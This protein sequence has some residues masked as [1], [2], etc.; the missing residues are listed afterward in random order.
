METKGEA[1]LPLG[2]FA[3]LG[4]GEARLGGAEVAV[5][6]LGVAAK[7]GLVVDTLTCVT[8]TSVLVGE[9]TCPA[10][11]VPVAWTMGPLLSVILLSMVLVSVDF[12]DTDMTFHSMPTR[13]T[14]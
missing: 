11:A 6:P 1:G 5:G 2:R 14:T 8:V 9:M 12:D 7:R 10:W 4:T 3:W 13:T